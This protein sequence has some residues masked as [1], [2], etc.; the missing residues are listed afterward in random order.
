[1]RDRRRI[2]GLD[3]GARRIG[4]ALS[5]EEARIAFPEGT[6][7]RRSLEADLT[8]LRRLIEERGVGRIVVGLPK[9][10]SGRLGPEA[11]AAQTFAAR[12]AEATG[13]PVDT[14]DERWTTREAER[15]LRASGRKGARRRAVIDAVAASLI[16]DT[17]LAQRRRLEQEGGSPR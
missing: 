12:L 15:T 6:L 3:L 13:L 8:A 7:E 1:M 17:Y 9:H 16:L 2:L 14:L 10:M 5:D 11:E 4:L